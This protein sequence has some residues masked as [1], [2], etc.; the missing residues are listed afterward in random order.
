MVSNKSRQDL[1]GRTTKVVT[2]FATVSSHNSENDLDI[3]DQFTQICQGQ[4]LNC[5]NEIVARLELQHAL[6]KRERV[7]LLPR[8]ATLNVFS[9]CGR[10][11]IFPSSFLLVTSSPLECNYTQVSFLCV[12]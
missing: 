3:Y 5:V 8:I 11:W 2:A 1:A 6:F 4:F 9:Q 7:W 10:N 12:F